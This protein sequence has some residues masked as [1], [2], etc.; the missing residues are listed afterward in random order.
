GQT[1]SPS[2]NLNAL[3]PT[4]DFVGFTAGSAPA[5]RTP[6]ITKVIDMGGSTLKVGIEDNGKADAQTDGTSIPDISAGFTMNAGSMSIFAGGTLMNAN[7]TVKGE[8]TQVVEATASVKMD[9]GGMKLVGS[10]AMIG[11][12]DTN[13]AES[14]A[15]SA[16][17][18]IPV[19]G[20]MSVN[21]MAEVQSYGDSSKEDQST[22]FVNAFYKMPS[23]LEFGA[24]VQNV[25]AVGGTDGS[26]LTNINFQG[27]FAF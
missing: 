4:I 8:A 6:Q 25:T 14:T 20:G 26:D 5:G 12:D 22:V 3:L 23:G 13:V 27:K 16:G 24:E 10:F 15:F 21:A 9:M 11:D 7:D 17:V 2:A 19:G 18:G 1:W